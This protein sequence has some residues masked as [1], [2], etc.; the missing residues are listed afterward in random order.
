[1]E[2]TQR[3]TLIIRT[4]LAVTFLVLMYVIFNYSF[5]SVAVESKKQ[6]NRIFITNSSGETIFRQV[7]SKNESTTLLVKRG[8]R[9]VTVRADNAESRLPLK[10]RPLWSGSYR[11]S[12]RDQVAIQ[13]QGAN[14]LNCGV[15]SGRNILYTYRCSGGSD[16]IRNVVENNFPTTEVVLD[17][18]KTNLLDPAQ[19]LGGILSITQPF[20]DDP[21]EL[22]RV[23]LGE[24]V[25]T[26]SVRIPYSLGIDNADEL[27]VVTNATD[28]NDSRFLLVDASTNKLYIFTKH[29]DTNPRTVD[30]Q[31]GIKA[32]PLLTHSC[33]L[34]SEFIAC[35]YGQANSSIDGEV[36]EKE[37]ESGGDTI[38]TLYSFGG[39]QIIRRTLKENGVVSTIAVSESTIAALTANSELILY[40]FKN[41][42]FVRNGSSAGVE[43][44]IPS[45]DLGIL[46]LEGSSIYATNKNTLQTS[47]LLRSTNLRISDFASGYGAGLFTAFV[48]NQRDA[49]LSTYKL[50]NKPQVGS[51]IVDKLP[52]SRD[53]LIRELDYIGDTLYIRLALTSYTSDQETGEFTV[54]EPEYNATRNEVLRQLTK[55]GIDKMFERIVFSY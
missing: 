12:L 42:N 4:L 19:Y 22:S 30:L 36:N 23:T 10:F 35:M 24:T 48:N 54:D 14:T 21:Y 18:N 38:L 43:S 51:R 9:L 33:S 6:V 3:R 45:K 34:G 27:S 26:E 16:V 25:V 8:D 15:E 49:K 53:S 11:I 39:D 44:I 20:A 32:Q 41:G 52:T 29:K 47:L 2:Q 28:S 5:V 46:A 13:R 1:M 7:V 37:V 40:Q 50:T 31:D 17:K 55:S